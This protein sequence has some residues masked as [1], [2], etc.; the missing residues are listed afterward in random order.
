MIR[1]LIPADSEFKKYDKE[2]KSLYQEN[3]EKICDTNSY[4]FV[5]DNTLFY[6]FLDD[7]N[8]FGAIYYFLDD[9]KLFLNAFSKRKYFMQ[10]IQALSLSITWFTCDIYAE[11]Q[12]KAS[13][14]TLLRCGFKRVNGKLF[15]YERV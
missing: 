12:N 13:A 3:Q 15:K 5:R 14:F 11:A 6:A 7:K 2:L 10:N 8:L 1:V 4:E 9:G